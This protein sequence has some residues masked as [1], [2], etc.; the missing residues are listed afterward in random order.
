MKP[1]TVCL[2]LLMLPSAFLWAQ[3]GT[4]ASPAPAVS[5]PEPIS[6]PMLAPPPVSGQAFPTSFTSE[7]RS[8]YLR[9]GLAFTTAYTDN[10]IGSLAGHPVSDVG[11]SVAPMI[12]LDETTP[13]MH[14]V[15]SYA[16][17][18]TFYQR[19]NAL[20]EQDQN[21][22]IDFSYRLSPHVTFSARDSFQKSS[23]IFN[24]PNL[25]AST[26][27]SGDTQSGN[28][29]VIAPIAD[30]LSNSGNVG[31]TYQFA[32]NAMVGASGTFTNLHYPDQAQVPGL[33]DSSSQAGLAFYA[34]RISR[35]HYVGVT[36]QYQR[37]LAYP[38]GGQNETQTHAA[39]F[40][41]SFYPTSKVSFSVF[42]GPQFANAQPAVFRAIADS[43]ACVQKLEPGRWRQ[44]ELAEPAERF[45]RQLCA[46]Y[47]Q[48]RR[49]DR[50]GAVEQRNRVLPS[51]THAHAEWYGRNRL[52][53]E[54][55]FDSIA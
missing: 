15:L 22:A 32:A 6:E 44:R 35:K 43:D 53:A 2:V 25:A 20:N 29:S 26:V 7:E 19:E 51:A 54:R 12:A 31:L 50:C 33:S 11:Y 16:P 36:Y 13:R 55:S 17:G 10:A 30:R 18:F 37:L 3:G 1:I 45:C 49:I 27:V 14:T 9:G 48:W 23:N 28:F 4:Q 42:G 40:F 24:Q 34:L 41:Y 5:G 21:A 39:L 47:R 46:P 52:C 8:N 38:V